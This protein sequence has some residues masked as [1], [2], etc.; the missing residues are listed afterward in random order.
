MAEQVHFKVFLRKNNSRNDNHAEIRR[1]AIDTDVVTNFTYLREKLQTV[2]PDLRGKRF[3][4][5]WK[6]FENDEIVIC[7]CEELEIALAE[8]QKYPLCKL[9]VTLHSDYDDENN[10]PIKSPFVHFEATNNPKIKHAGIVCDGCDKSVCGFRYKCVQCS[11]YDLCSECEAKGLHPEHCMIRISM[12]LQWR[13]HYGRRLSHHINKFMKKASTC[14]SSAEE[15]TKECPFKP[16]RHNLYNHRAEQSPSWIDTFTTYLNDWA[17]LPGECPVMGE[18]EKSKTGTSEQNQSMANKTSSASTNENNPMDS[19]VQFLKNFSE[20]ISQFLDPLGIDVNVQVKADESPITEKPLEDTKLSQEYLPNLKKVVTD[21]DKNHKE[22]TDELVQSAANDSQEKN[23]P[24]TKI[25]AKEGNQVT[26]N[27]ATKADD[28]TLVDKD[29]VPASSEIASGK[30]A[31]NEKKPSEPTVENSKATTD[32]KALYPSL[33]NVSDNVWHPN[34][35]IQRAVEAMMQM[36][37]S[38]EGGWL[39]QL[40]ISKNGDISR[41]LDVL[42]PVRQ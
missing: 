18:Q 40:L 2:F 27:D 9:F 30:I 8:L 33:P 7:S 15:E 28:W 42:Q 4:I 13:S 5:T 3:T 41:A 39:T 24:I 38:N 22:A 11:D 29:S 10:C 25:N 1:F 21:D 26:V 16:R 17:N 36:G 31:Q 37:F 34:P 23:K 6:D 12:P 32:D 20:N 35:K 14:P 19:H